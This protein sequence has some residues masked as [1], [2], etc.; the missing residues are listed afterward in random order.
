LP[1]ALFPVYEKAEFLPDLGHGHSS[2]ARFGNEGDIYSWGKTIVMD[3]K[4]FPQSAFQL[5]S[6]NGPPDFS[7]D[8]QPE[9]GRAVRF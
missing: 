1:W 9:P 4:E 8:C 3:S 7:T 5:I 2:G 6:L